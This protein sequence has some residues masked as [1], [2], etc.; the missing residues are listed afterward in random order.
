MIK[1]GDWTIAD[2]IKYLVSVQ[3]ALSDSEIERLRQ[4]EAFSAEVA[5][6]TRRNAHRACDLYEPSGVHRQLGLPLINWGTQPKWRAT[7]EEGEVSRSPVVITDAVSAKFLFR[8]GLRRFPPLEVVVN[9]AAS[10]DVAIRSTAL[11]YLVD[12]IGTR[13]VDYDPGKFQNVAYVPALL[14]GETCMSTPQE[15]A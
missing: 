4:T 7:S 13:Y 9:L 1:T 6:Q 15:V 2:L 11:R 10:A 12:N 5:P 8:L 14:N 3:S